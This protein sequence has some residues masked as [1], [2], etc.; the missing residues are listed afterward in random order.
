MVSVSTPTEGTGMPVPWMALALATVGVTVGEIRKTNE[1]LEKSI[2]EMQD[3]ERHGAFLLKLRPL[4]VESG[5]ST[6]EPYAKLLQGKSPTYLYTQLWDEVLQTKSWYRVYMLVNA[7]NPRR[8]SMCGSTL[9]LE[10]VHNH[11]MWS[12]IQHRTLRMGMFTD[13]K[14]DIL[15]KQLDFF[16]DSRVVWAL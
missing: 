6:L 4:L 15:R 2:T 3:K 14:Y 16:I 11:L 5:L 8:C 10:E 1:E 7:N 9:H 13:A 12:C